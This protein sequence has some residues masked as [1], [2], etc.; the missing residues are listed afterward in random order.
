[1]AIN[2]LSS[3]DLNKNQLLNAAIQ[4]LGSDPGTG[5]EGQIYFN[6]TD[7]VLKV[8][9]GGNWVNVA[10]QG[11]ITA[12]T[13]ATTNQLTV[14]DSTGPAPALTIVTG[15]IADGATNLVTSDVIFDAIA[16][17][18]DGTVTSI[19]FGAGLTGGTITS[20][21]SVALDLAGTDNYLL[22]G[23]DATSTTLE[24]GFKIAYS[25]A[26]DNVKFG[27]VSDLPF[28]T[29]N[30]TV[31]S[32]TAGDGITITGTST[33]DPTVKVNSTVVRTT[34]AQSIAGVKTFSDQVVVPL[35]PTASTNVA[36][37][38]YVL[39]QIG[40][41]GGF[42]G[43]YNAATNTPALSGGS[44][45][46]MALG[47]FFVVS[48][49]GDNGAFFTDL[50]PG[51]F[52]FA[53]AAIAASSS[54]SD[55]AYTVVVADQ[56]IAGAGATDGATIKGVTGFSNASFAVNVNGF[57]TIKNG[58]IALG[59][60]TSGNYIEDITTAGDGLA[61][62]IV[63]ESATA[64]LTLTLGSIAA[65]DGTDFVMA[66]TGTPG[67]QYLTPIATAAGLI[68][69]KS[70]FAI[71][72]GDASATSF[73]VTHNLAA[74]DVIVQLY[75]NS[76]GDTVYADTVRTNANVVTIDFGTAPATNDIRVLV[77]K[78]G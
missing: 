69:A 40:G 34:G 30:G 63:G 65:G 12:V 61:G 52:V 1:M 18:A 24:A 5:V 71:S 10:P 9:A 78:I 42:R 13:S 66:D 74:T 62:G 36:S 75:D 2:F 29:K 49:A 26:S 7:D 56:N 53:D 27:L 48:V 64:A 73:T 76:T 25:D 51:D 32:V 37:K 35:T 60:Q 44:N 22:V 43:G 20:S 39:S 77:Q 41:V 54:P 31:T 14:A 45:V 50:E 67:S 16:A 6:T 33:V 17:S 59:T 68:N 23:G 47:D 15:S 70:T 8:Y 46:A 72:I 38:G 4:N 28:N 19:A 55:S 11:D 21:G 58:G 3:I 57:T